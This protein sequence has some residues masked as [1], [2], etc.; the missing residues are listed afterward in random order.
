MSEVPLYPFE[1]WWWGNGFTRPQLVG[2]LA[3]SAVGG[4]NLL[5]LF[6]SIPLK[7]RV[8][9][10]INIIWDVFSFLFGIVDGSPDSKE[11]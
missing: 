11:S 9:H 6:F 7:P 4:G 8:L 2:V 5:P 10:R 1:W 3:P